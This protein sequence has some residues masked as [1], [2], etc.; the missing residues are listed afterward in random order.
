MA[1]HAKQE[2]AVGK[3]IEMTPTPKV[4]SAPLLEATSALAEHLL[5]SEP[6]LRFQEAD[7]K[8]QTNQEAMGL[9]TEA[10]E[11]QQKVRG[12]R[13]SGG[14][15]ESDIQRLR[16]LQNMIN[17][18]ETIQEQG[19]AQELAIVFLR[20]VNQEISSLLGVDFASLTRRSSGC[21]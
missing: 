12:Q 17:T 11:L 10:A 21:C 8:L 4:V 19:K 18:N 20:E 16:E 5:L 7:R 3:V 15:S 9:L 1:L 6:F 14:I 2:A 13:K